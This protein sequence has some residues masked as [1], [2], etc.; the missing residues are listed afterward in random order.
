MG[1]IHFVKR[2]RKDNSV[3]KKGESY[4]WWCFKYSKEKHYSKEYPSTEQLIESAYE[5]QEH[6]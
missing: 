4:Y 5:E 3:A 6:V 1:N 2:A